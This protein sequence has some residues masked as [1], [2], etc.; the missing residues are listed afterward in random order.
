MKILIVE[1]DGPLRLL[2]AR[3]LRDN[4]FE[5]VGVSTAAE[6][7]PLIE[8]GGFQMVVLD[9]MLPGTNGLDICRW[10]R[11]RTSLPIIIIS[12]RA[13][14][15]DR[16]VGLELGADDY[17]S[18][19]FSAEELVARVRAVLRRV[20]GEV[21]AAPRVR[22]LQFD[23]WTVDQDRREL[24]AP[25]GTQVPISGAEY[26]L[27]VTLAESS[28]RVVSRE[29]LLEQTRERFSGA[30]DR[31]IDV[32]VSRLRSK[33]GAHGDGDKLIKTVRG[34]GYMF[35]PRVERQ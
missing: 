27:L 30:S 28:Q 17:L 5:A 23:G 13:R 26:E 19:P 15:T 34:A 32:L 18:K 14:D 4:G 21:S 16:I 8:T 10:L 9:I 35:L 11:A 7:R 22:A 25:D 24:R 6:M 2:I 12:A 1:D 3:A 29:F 20:N 33:L 31:S